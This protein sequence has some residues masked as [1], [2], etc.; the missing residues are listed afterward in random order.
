MW[1]PCGPRM[2]RV[3]SKYHFRSGLLLRT[4]PRTD[5]ARRRKDE[6]SSCP[7]A[8]PVRWKS[9]KMSSKFNL[10][11]N[12]CTRSVIERKRE[13][14]SRGRDAGRGEGIMCR[15]VIHLLTAG[16]HLGWSA[17]FRRG[18]NRSLD[19]LIDSQIWG[20]ELGHWRIKGRTG[21]A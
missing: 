19:W 2:L 16:A 7:V 5:A 12:M 3:S 14:T 1:I 17:P 15:C 13:G 18:C 9:S 11:A 10:I 4:A 20:N 6:E 21:L 8:G